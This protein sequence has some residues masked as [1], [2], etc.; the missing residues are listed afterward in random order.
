MLKAVGRLEEGVAAYRRA[1]SVQADLGEVWWSLANLKTVRFSDEDVAAMEA[2]L[3][4]A[5]SHHNR[6]HLHFALGK[7]YGDRQQA[8]AS[9]R[10]FAAG[11]ALRSEELEY[12]PEAITRPVEEIGRAHCRVRECG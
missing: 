10:H 7:A 5:P 1:L 12:D 4:G 3:A 11:T 8:E 9:F 2:A 6:L